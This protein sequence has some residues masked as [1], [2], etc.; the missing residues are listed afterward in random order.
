M[1]AAMFI[2]VSLGTLGGHY[3]PS[4]DHRALANNSP[5]PAPDGASPVSAVTREQQHERSRTP[6]VGRFC[7]PAR[8]ATVGAAEAETAE[9]VTVPVAEVRMGAA[10]S[11]VDLGDPLA[12]V[13]RVWN[14]PGYVVLRVG[15]GTDVLRDDG[16][17]V[18]DPVAEHHAAGLLGG[19]PTGVLDHV[20]EC[21]PWE[22]DPQGW[23]RR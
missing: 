16:L 4:S 17:A 5:S 1:P 8:R 15:A 23:R 11:L 6:R 12:L 19:A 22:P 21:G 13:L 3:E 2:G 9:W 10:R 14:E 7:Y 20:V 18:I